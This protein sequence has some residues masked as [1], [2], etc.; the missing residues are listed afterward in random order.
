MLLKKIDAQKVVV[1]KAKDGKGILHRWDYIKTQIPCT[2]LMTL[3]Y[4]E[5]E[6]GSSI[7]KHQHVDNF[8]AYYFIDG[9][10]VAVDNDKEVVVTKGDLLI[11]EDG[12]HHALT[13]TGQT[14]LRFLAFIAAS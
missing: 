13:N 3:S 12:E 8:E 10:G 1:E 2:S 14:N 7:G 4:L 11:T 5:L 9:D 6:P